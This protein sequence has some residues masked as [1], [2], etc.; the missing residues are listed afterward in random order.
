MQFPAFP[1]VSPEQRATSHFYM[2]YEDVAQDGALKVGAMPA[3]VGLVFSRLWARSEQSQQLR[4]VGILPLLTRLVLQTTG[5][6][7]SVHAKVEVDGGYQLGHQRG[8]DG[9][10][11]RIL[12]NCSVELHAPVG[13]T[14]PPQPANAGERVH[15]GRVFAEHVFTRP[16]AAAGN[17]KVL[18]LPSAAGEHV[19]ETQFASRSPLDTLAVEPTRWLEDAPRPDVAPTVFGLIHTDANQHVNSLVY[20]RVFEEAALRRLAALGHSTAALA[21]ELIEVSY[22][23]PCF[24]GEQMLIALR[25]FEQDGALGVVGY[26]GP[27]GCAAEQAH[28]MCQ[29]R[30]RDGALPG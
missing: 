26:L 1:D 10:V 22:R 9:H 29:L 2:R 30:F 28:C 24:A 25:A 11:S 20:P 7:T 19:P 27:A 18:A 3:A 12:L 21:V 23:K 13:R 6:P 8:L 17:R 15:V 14:H 16:F 5:G 4:G